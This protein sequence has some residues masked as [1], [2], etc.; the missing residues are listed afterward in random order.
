M[1][2]YVLIIAIE[3]VMDMKFFSKKH[4]FIIGEHGISTVDTVTIG[5]IDQT[6]LIQGVDVTKPVLLLLHGG[7]SLPLP[8]VSSRGYDYTIVTNTRQLVKHYILVFWD[9]R[10]TGK[11]YHKSIRQD[12]MSV[13][14][15][16]SDTIELTDYLRKRFDQDKIFLAGHSWGSI[17]GLMAIDRHPEKYYSYVGISQVINWT[18]NDRLGLNWAK[19]EA[20]K[21][22]N[23]KALAELHAVGEPPFIESFEQWAVLRRWQRKFGTLVYTDKHIK[24]PGLSKIT[25]DMLRSTE[26]SLKDMFN[27][28]YRGFQLVYTYDFINDLPQIDF[29]RSTPKVDI[30]VTFIHGTKDVHVHGLLVEQYLEGLDTAHGKCMIWL[31]KSGHAFH[32]DDTIEIERLLI[33]EL[34]YL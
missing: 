7:P 14:Q 21:R 1:F 33:E 12:S 20:K 13:A 28:F 2:K 5:G 29:T 17:M 30:P 23:N 24:H 34:Q 18:D 32:P 6:I 10:G 9:Q 4:D 22:S 19:K 11:S 3:S 8:G 31:D 26:Y 25:L 16:V 15:F 27:T